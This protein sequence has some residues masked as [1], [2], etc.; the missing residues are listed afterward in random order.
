MLFISR[1]DRARRTEARFGLIRPALWILGCLLALVAPVETARGD[2]PLPDVEDPSARASEPESP[3]PELTRE[4]LLKS[5]DPAAAKGESEIERMERAIAGM[6]QAFE[7]I[8]ASD[9][10]EETLE[11]QRGVIKDLEEL[12]KR[13]RQQ[14][15][16]K[17]QKNS[18]SPQQQQKQ[19]QQQERQSAR[20]PQLDPQNS[21]QPQPQKPQ[22]GNTSQRGDN[23]KAS[24]SQERL[25]AARAALAAEAARG[26]MV[27]DVW[28]HLP[29]HLRDAMKNSFSEKYLPKYEDL[30]K[31][32][33]EA[34]AE[35]NRKRSISN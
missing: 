29:P 13:L 7:R 32:Y 4:K 26:R 25:E 1:I 24:D 10:S 8:E 23:E 3:L 19:N 12:V 20:K 18:N 14:Q 6:R 30:V 15:Q 27:K 5:I 17:Q 11:V 34:L 31:R 33:Y 9:L 22:A 35:K 16:Q 21:G 28:G 2:D